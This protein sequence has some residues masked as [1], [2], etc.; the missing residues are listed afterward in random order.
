MQIV[1][2][3]DTH[4][5]HEKIKLPDGDILIYAG[6]CAVDGTV[7]EVE[8][9]ANWLKSQPHKY[10]CAIAGNH[11]DCLQDKPE[12]FQDNGIEYLCDRE[13]NFG[14]LRIYGTPWRSVPRERMTGSKIRW[15]AFMITEPW[16]EYVFSE[17]PSGLDI[18]VSHQPPLGIMDVG[19]HWKKCEKA[20][21]DTV[22]GPDGKFWKFLGY[23]SWGNKAL[24]ENIKRAKPK[25]SIF[26]HVHDTSGI[27]VE[28]GITFY[29]VSMCDPDY[30]LRTY[31]TTFEV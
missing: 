25:H 9:F 20:D 31:V 16:D 8:N 26:G 1:A 27:K 29:N 6:D 4:N 11:D 22:T 18:L 24:L 28:D 5:Q 23:K 12:I 7:K 3:S 15:S 17:I 13:V 10:K 30:I 19:T 21:Q 14:G 2:F